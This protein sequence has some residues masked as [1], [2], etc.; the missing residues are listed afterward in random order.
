[1]KKYFTKKI[2]IILAI[3]V[4][5]FAVPSTVY[6][7]QYGKYNST[8]NK[9]IEL[10]KNDKFDEGINTL[11]SIE[12]SRFT[13]KKKAISDNISKA[14]KLNKSYKDFNEGL[15]IQGQKKYLEAIEFFKKVAK[16]DEKRY[17]EAEKKI[18]ECKNSYIALNLD[19]AKKEAANGKYESA[20]NY[21]EL[22][23]KEDA[24]SKD[25]SALKAEYNNAIKVAKEKEEQAKREAEAKKAEAQRKS[26]QAKKDAQ[27]IKEAEER[28]KLIPIKPE[29][30]WKTP[31]YF[32]GF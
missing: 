13:S 24:N 8:Y 21:V 32:Q 26:A 19:A 12:N 14:E 10:I 29:I 17:A 5:V 1:M 15:N 25:A 28:L 27:F 16:E 31:D 9:G 20:L 4:F 30:Q 22:I 7:Y 6:G 18:N 2:I 3:I 11:R 23:L